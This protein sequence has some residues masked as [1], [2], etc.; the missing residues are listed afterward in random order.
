VVLVSQESGFC[1]WL[2][3]RAKQKHV[4][5]LL[6]L[7]PEVGGGERETPRLRSGIIRFGRAEPSFPHRIAAAAANPA[8]LNL[9]PKL[10]HAAQ[11]SHITCKKT[12]I[13]R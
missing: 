12:I 8:N 2:S 9:R 3:L 5:S 7:V 13:W 10:M 11:N 4:P 6:W 1:E